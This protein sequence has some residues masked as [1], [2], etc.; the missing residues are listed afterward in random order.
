MSTEPL[1]TEQLAAKTNTATTLLGE[2]SD[3]P[4]PFSGLM[5]RTGRIL[6]YL[7]SVDAIQEVAINTFAANNITRSLTIP[8]IQS[9]IYHKYLPALGLPAH[10]LT[11]CTVSTVLVP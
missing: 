2:P 5:V 9:A 7:A 1:T 11:P 3:P 8:G 6:R 4:N 10:S